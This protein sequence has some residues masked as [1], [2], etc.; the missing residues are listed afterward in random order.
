M[1]GGTAS[2][3]LIQPP[4]SAHAT[5]AVIS[6]M[7]SGDDILARLPTRLFLAG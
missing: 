7:P 6:R 5:V 2:A 4:H 3:A 1:E